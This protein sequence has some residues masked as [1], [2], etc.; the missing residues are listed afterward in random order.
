VVEASQRQRL[1]A[2]VAVEVVEHGYADV[3]ILDLTRGAGLS[4]RTFYDHFADK[5]EAL[6]GAYDAIFAR[7]VAAIQSACGSESHWTAKVAAAVSAAVRFAAV[8]PEAT[9]LLTVDA[10]AAFPAATRRVL[11]S[12]ELLAAMLAG[13]R[14]AGRRAAAL[15]QV[16]ERALVASLWAFLGAE[17]LRSGPD[18]LAEL[19]PELVEFALI[20]YRGR[21]SSRQPGASR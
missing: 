5:E 16:T 20:P 2:A 8:E 10:V 19:E 17:L 18:R 12:A 1:L 21:P 6:L 9:R 15:P 11:D 7:L 3:T 14:R 4:R 13:A